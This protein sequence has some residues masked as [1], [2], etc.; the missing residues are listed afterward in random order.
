LLA[1][2]LAS[3]AELRKL[4]QTLSRAPQ[5]GPEQAQHLQDLYRRVHF[6]TAVAGLTRYTQIAQ[7]AS[8]FEALLYVLTEK[9]TL[10]G[11]SVQRTLANL[12]DFVEL[13]FQRARESRLDVPSSAK[14]LAVDDDP[15]SNELVVRALREH[16]IQARSTEDPLVAWQWLQ[17]EHFDLVLL[18]IEMPGLTGFELCKRLR[19]VPAYKRTPVIFVTS[20]GDFANRAQSTL[21][22][23]D[24]L[25]AKPVLPMEL[26]AKV[27]MHLLKSGMA[28]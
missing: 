3:C 25:L 11:L 2:A 26:T 8:V 21:S 6:L 27:L 10:L 22:G 9:P 17:Q 14:V 28:A 20:H 7:V 23:G 16:E 15:L 12:V 19:T 5:A 1:K 13:L 24:D 4:L 18:D